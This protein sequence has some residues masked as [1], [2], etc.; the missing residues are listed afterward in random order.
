MIKR[1]LLIAATLAKVGHTYSQSTDSSNDNKNHIIA[2]VQYISNQSYLGRT[3][4]LRLPVIVPSVNFET[5]AGFYIK[6]SGYVNLSRNNQGFDGIS[7]EPGYEFSKGNWNG[8]ISFI[9]N[10][11]SD[12]S[13]LI[14]APMKASFEFYL[15]NENKIITPSVGAEYI[16]SNEGNDFIFYA[17]LAKLITLAKDEKGFSATLEPSVSAGGGTQSFYYSYLKHYAQNGHSKSK[18]TGQNNNSVPPDQTLKEESQQFGLLTAGFELPISLTKGKLEWKTTP[19]LESPLNLVNEGAE[20]AQ[21]EKPYWYI[22]SELVY[23]F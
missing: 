15:E 20:G 18:G 2:G 16:F 3:D 12:S 10:F 6:A 4:S 11:I 22:S 1:I 23:T 5:R 7:I 14:I 19:A 17:G 9:K 8:S 13:N 21:K